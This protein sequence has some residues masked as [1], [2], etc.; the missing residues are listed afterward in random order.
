MPG[1]RA[2]TQYNQIGVWQCVRESNPLSNFVILRD[3]GASV[4]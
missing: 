1:G 2:K 3:F 4:R